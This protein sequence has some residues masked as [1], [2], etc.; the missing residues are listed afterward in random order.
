M[1][2]VG[3]KTV[4]F[5]LLLG[6]F[7]MSGRAAFQDRY[8]MRTLDAEQGL[9]C[10]YV[11]DVLV[12][13]AGF[14][15][16]ATSGGGLCRY[17][18][19]ELLPFNSSTD[20][21]LSSNFVRNLVEDRFHRLWVASEGGLQVFDLYTLE[22]L[23][24]GVDLPSHGSLCSCVV[25]DAGG[26]V[27]TKFGDTLY[28]IGFDETGV[29]GSILS[30]T[31]P[32][33]DEVNHVL[34]DVAGDGSVWTRLGRAFYRIGVSASGE[35]LEA[36]RVLPTLEL[37]DEHTY[38]SDYLLFESSLWIA[39]ENGLYR[40]QRGTGEWRRY[41]HSPSDSRS[42]TQN[43]VSSLAVTQ[44]GLILASTLHGLN[45]YNSVTDSFER[46][47]E[48]I[49]N[50]IKTMD[51][52]LMV[53]TENKG[54]LFFEPKSLNISNVTHI[55]GDPSSLA[56]G[57]VNAIWQEPDGRLWVGSV[58]GGLSV[59][60]AGGTSFY[61]LTR[62]KG[63]LA[64]NS[65]SAIRP[66]PDHQ[67]YVGT[68]GS[69]IDVV[70]AGPRPRVVS[71]LPALGT[72]TDYIG[73]LE[74]DTLHDLLWIGSNR[75]I[76]LYDPSARRIVEAL[77][78]PVSGC[79]GSCIDGNHQ[80]WIGCLEGLYVFDLEHPS[81]N[82]RFPFVHYRYKLDQPESRSEEKICC[83]LESSPDEI[84][85]G[86]N[87]GGLY[88]ARRQPD[89]SYRFTNYS[90][91]QGLSSDRVRGLCKDGQGRIWVS[92]EYGLNLLNP[93]TG[94][95]T[96]FL[97]RDG[98]RSVQFHWNNACS[99]EDGY[100]YFGHAEGYSVVHPADMPSAPPVSGNLRFTK[101]V[102]GER[103]PLRSPFLKEVQLHEKDR[104]ALF[105]FAVLMP[106]A[107][108]YVR[109]EYQLEGY[110]AAP[111]SLPPGRREV[112]YS[113]LKPGRYTFRVTAYN[114]FGRQEGSLQLTVRVLPFF[115]H[116]WWFALLSFILAVAL[117]ILLIRFRT[118]TLQRRQAELEQT[119]AER[120]REISAQKKLV[121][122]KA[123][124]LRHQNDVLLHQNEELASR[125]M[126]SVRQ[127]DPFKEKVLGILRNLYRNP[128]LDVNVLCQAMGMSKT[129]LNTRLQEAF[130]QSTGQLIRTY[131]LT[132]AREMLESGSGVT[133]AEVAYDVGFNDPKYFTRCFTKEFGIPPSA[134]SKA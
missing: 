30:F 114:R 28:R 80:L 113:S 124:E 62:E 67:M 130:G 40:V 21:S 71:H 118:R 8:L 15:W 10:N 59:L 48:A 119:V 84:Y 105:Q 11:D 55:S 51:D 97:Q 27:W 81:D 100:L 70:S 43:F 9:P 29:P 56:E 26:T 17:D 126:L 23:D 93:Q 69:G 87:G 49:I 24:L 57:A 36:V 35:S 111:R 64:H 78:D 63:G 122:K 132:L 103:P 102:L 44:D 85:L 47:G 16:I 34:E 77:D 19:Y 128:D 6:L 96:S 1:N 99:G 83:I 89:G 82:G 73:V 32:G 18:G 112:G 2:G 50:G 125:K 25:T 52:R 92:T 31:H 74:Y 66:G 33:M 61:H 12:D 58:E 110:D 91:R 53:A 46:V 95:I 94:V 14:L 117:T 13:S 90:T 72:L 79:I 5:L 115:Y 39:T 68:W 54:L 60:E 109:Y 108:A 116:T 41:G 121:E 22:K 20:P 104:T 88:R 38:V 45:V 120:T 37:E 134:A 133:V 131:R 86:S 3:V 127:D 107:A 129:L 42:L 4:F 123:E 101:V 7:P 76:F 65:V 106:D 98:L 75:G